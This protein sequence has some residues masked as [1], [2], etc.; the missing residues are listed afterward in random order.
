[1][2]VAERIISF[3]N[4]HLPEAIA[5]DGDGLG[6][7]VVDQLQH[8]GYTKGLFESHGGERPRDF[9]MHFNRRSEVWRLMRDWFHKG[10]V[11]IPDDPELEVD[12]TGPEYG[13]SSKNQIQLER[14]EDMKRRG[15][16]SPDLGDG[17]A[18]TFAVDIA[19]RSQAQTTI[20]LPLSFAERMD[21]I[22]KRSTLVGSRHY[23]NADV[24]KVHETIVAP[25]PIGIVSII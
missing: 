7:G 13:F 14:K 20:G 2:Q 5:V 1:M 9:N 8:H 19:F 21:G 24:R 18:M 25:R 12:L 23:G 11:E 22:L 6:D 4:K 16:A 3:R 15:L 10:S 17:L